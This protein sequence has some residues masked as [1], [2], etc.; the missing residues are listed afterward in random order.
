[1][2]SSIFVL[3]TLDKNSDIRLKELNWQKYSVFQPQGIGDTTRS[4]ALHEARDIHTPN[5]VRLASHAVL[6]MAKHGLPLPPCIC[7]KLTRC[8]IQAHPTSRLQKCPLAGSIVLNRHGEEQIRILWQGRA[9]EGGES[10]TEGARQEG[11]EESEAQ[12]IFGVHARRLLLSPACPI[13][14]TCP[15]GRHANYATPR[16]YRQAGLISRLPPCPGPCLQARPIPKDA[17]R[18]WP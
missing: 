11:K 14:P 6:L 2:H 13:G 4:A 9:G 15:L 10:L 12:Q 7:S 3:K 5:L 8:N 1:M 18:S 17:G 16:F